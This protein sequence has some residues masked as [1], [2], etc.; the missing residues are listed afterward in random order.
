MKFSICF[1]LLS[2]LSFAWA[3]PAPAPEGEALNPEDVP[4]A[5]ARLLGL[6]EEGEL[7]ETIEDEEEVEDVRR[8]RCRICVGRRPFRICLCR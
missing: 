6:A 4:A 8:R 7:V 5:L 3:Q 1:A 2:L